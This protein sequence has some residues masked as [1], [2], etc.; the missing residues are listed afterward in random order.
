[1]RE[2]RKYGGWMK[3]RA[4]KKEKLE[5]DPL[6]RD[7][8]DFMKKADWRPIS[9]LYELFEVQKKDTTITSSC[10]DGFTVGFKEDRN[11]R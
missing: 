7:L 6:D 4:S 9:D 8:S 10:S 2:K 11:E 5:R 3:K 1:M